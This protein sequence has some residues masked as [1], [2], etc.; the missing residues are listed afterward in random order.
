MLQKRRRVLELLAGA[1]TWSL[2]GCMSGTKNS[3]TTPGSDET[4]DRTPTV[5]PTTTLTPT[6]TP[7]DTATPTAAPTATPSDPAQT[8]KLAADDGDSEDEFG[9][10]VAISG[11]GSTAVIGAPFDE[12]P[13]G[14]NAGAAYVFERG[15]NAWRQRTKL[16]PDDGGEHDLFGVSVGIS[17]SGD[18]AAVGAENGENSDGKRVGAVYIFERTDGAWSQRA[19]ITPNDGTDGDDFGSS[20]DVS[21]DGTTLVVGNSDDDE[22]GDDAGSAYVFAR[23]NGK[24]IESVKLIPDDGDSDDEFGGSIALSGDGTVAVVAA[25]GDEDPHSGSAYVFERDGGGWTQQAK[26]AADADD[27]DDLFGHSVAVSDDG[28]VVLIGAVFYDPNGD[29][30]GAVYAYRRDGGSWTQ[31][32]LVPDDGSKGDHFGIDV[33]VVRGGNLAFVAANGVEGPNGE[34]VGATYV[35]ERSGDSWVQRARLVPDDGDAGDGFGEAIAASEDGHTAIVGANS[36]EDPN[37]SE[38]GSA[39]VFD[40]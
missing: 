37:G 26:L 18:L 13:N 21:A 31:T 7:T 11:D 35:F 39:Y 17:G 33:S 36:D 9:S 3:D 4:T 5:T 34:L 30:S 8:G 6:A 10:A 16:L 24:W 2:A 22:N 29:D 19:K 38:A 28:T 25:K 27:S 1:G 14:E 32:T 40:L 15:G 23:E 20:L 12:D